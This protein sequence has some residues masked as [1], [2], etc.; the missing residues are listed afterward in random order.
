M[1]WIVR[2]LAFAILVGLSLSAGHSVAQEEN[3]VVF[4]PALWVNIS[5]VGDMA[6]RRHALQEFLRAHQFNV[7][8]LSH[9][10]DHSGRLFSQNAELISIDAQNR[11]VT[12]STADPPA[13][14]ALTLQAPPSGTRGTAQLSDKLE[15]FARQSL[16]CT[17]GPA[18]HGHNAAAVASAYEKSA[19]ETASLI[20]LHSGDGVST[21]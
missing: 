4:R 7:L 18:H 11:I 19:H 16:Q 10:N 9:I 17:V 2:T 21:N 1:R 3:I 13:G 6:V 14:F 20:A 12:L 15:Q 5:C 8:D